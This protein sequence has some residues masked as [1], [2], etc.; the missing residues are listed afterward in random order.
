MIVRQN[1]LPQIKFDVN[2]ISPDTIA[3]WFEAPTV[4]KIL[5]REKK[6]TQKKISKETCWKTKLWGH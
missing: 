4:K 6:A 2:R 1:A 3:N 5:E